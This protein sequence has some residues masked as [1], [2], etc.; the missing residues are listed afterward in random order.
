MQDLTETTVTEAALEQMARTSDPRLR[1][2]MDAAVRHLHAFAH[3]ISL[4]PEEWLTGIKFLTD[5][6]HACTPIRQEFILLSDVLGVSALVNILHDKA[7]PEL[8]TQTS[9]LGPFYREQAPEFRAGGCIVANPTAPLITVYG[10]VVD[11][12]GR[13]IPGATVEVWQTDEHGLYDLQT[14]GGAKMDMRGLIR[15]DAEGKYHFRTV[16]PLGYSIPLDGPV[17]RLV[18][19]QAR[20]GFRPS[21]IHFLIAAPGFREL[22]T[23]LYFGDDA[24]VGSDTVFGVSASLVVTAQANDPNSP[25]PGLASGHYNFQLGRA[26]AQGSGRVG[27]DPSRVV[28]AGE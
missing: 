21:H 13:G 15:C 3:E 2:I 4:T 17:G 7:A 25:I 5:V 11:K 27:A 12:D 22:V 28:P 24:H 20:H 23:A 1:A 18:Q 16:R 9:L 6:G 14:D 10:R 8:G 26:A 19:S